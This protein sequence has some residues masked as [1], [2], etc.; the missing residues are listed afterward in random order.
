M[1]L[2]DRVAPLNAILE[3]AATGF[4]IP[5]PDEEHLGE[6]THDA[7]ELLALELPGLV[8]CSRPTSIALSSALL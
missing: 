6:E 1:L 3:P 5:L 2:L 8:P 4:R 7:D